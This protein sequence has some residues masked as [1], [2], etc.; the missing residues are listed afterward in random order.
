MCSSCCPSAASTSWRRASATPWRHRVSAG[1][2]LDS[3]PGVLRDEPLARHSQFGVGGPA[4]WF[5]T[6]RDVTVLGELLRRCRDSGVA[7]TMLG[8]GSNTLISDD[9]I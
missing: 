9:G 5:I 3:F 4:R 2:W 7:V 6:T 8:A 1:D